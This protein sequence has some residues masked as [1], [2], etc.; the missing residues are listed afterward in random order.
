MSIMI[1]DNRNSNLR[2]MKSEV[3]KNAY[4]QADCFIKVMK[5]I[6]KPVNEQLSSALALQ[7]E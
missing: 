4:L 5:S 2:S 3:H 6:Q 1:L 7:V